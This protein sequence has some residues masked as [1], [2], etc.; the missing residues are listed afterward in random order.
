[1]SVKKCNHCGRVACDAMLNTGRCDGT[2]VKSVEELQKEENSDRKTALLVMIFVALFLIITL[3]H[4]ADKQMIRAEK[5]EAENRKLRMQL[6]DLKKQQIE[7]IEHYTR[8]K[9]EAVKLLK[10]CFGN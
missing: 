1:M 2:E 9:E 7:T 4:I 5:A 3:G 8:Q 6:V 10:K